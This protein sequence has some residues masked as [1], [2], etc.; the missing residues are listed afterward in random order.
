MKR[1]CAILTALMLAVTLL[2]G[3]VSASGWTPSAVVDDDG[4]VEIY[5]PFGDAKRACLAAYTEDG[6]LIEA[7]FCWLRL[8][9]GKIYAGD[10]YKEAG[11]WKAFFLDENCCP[12]GQ[13]YWSKT[14]SAPK[15]A[16]S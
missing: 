10:I 3:A 14:L 2:T 4:V 8:G 1:F 5:V 11:Y 13:G 9:E 15:K 12:V 16:D 7:R 6:R